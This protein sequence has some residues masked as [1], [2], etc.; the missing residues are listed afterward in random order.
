MGYYTAQDALDD[1]ERCLELAT[2]ATLKYELCCK[3]GISAPYPALKTGGS[4]V[5]LAAKRAN[6][7]AAQF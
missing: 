6:V 5:A 7:H 1:T 4:P 2:C 3:I